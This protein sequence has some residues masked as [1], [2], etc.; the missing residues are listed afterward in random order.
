M[1]KAVFLDF[2]G[3]VYSHKSDQIPESTIE[4][5]RILREKGIRVFLCTG[6]AV[7]EMPAFDL[8]G[9]PLDAWIL[10]NGQVILDE[11]K[12]IIYEQKI[13][14]ELRDRILSLFNERTIP[15]YMIT[16]DDIYLNM[17][18][19][20]V[21]DVQQAVSSGIPKVKE[22]EGEDIYMASAF[23][24]DPKEEERLKEFEDIAEITW[25]HE[26]AV[27]IVPKGVSKINGINVILDR[28]GI[29]KEET[30]AVGDGH[31]DISM[32][33]YCQIGV[34][35]GNSHPE[36]LLNADYVTDDID[37]DGLYNALKHFEL[38]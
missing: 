5:V 11:D 25:W 29:P 34:A 33:R 3:T 13:E 15:M 37:D 19:Q 21:L 36:T 26:G 10:S 17:I 31:N 12:N 8:S 16:I 14:G 38:I 35:M 28:Y 24:S 7:G 32:I 6:R 30:M 22:Y 4:A 2:D 27:D 9:F 1:I 18:N 23:F 20:K